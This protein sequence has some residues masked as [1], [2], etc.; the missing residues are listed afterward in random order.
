MS[1]GEV[2]APVRT[3]QGFH[4]IKVLERHGDRPRP[5]ED[6]K[7]DCRGAVLREKQK[8]AIGRVV[9]R[10]RATAEIVSHVEQ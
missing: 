2:S 6:V 10:L 5:F 9:A 1:P 8:E 4:I 7:E 3:Y